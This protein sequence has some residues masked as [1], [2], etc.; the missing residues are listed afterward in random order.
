MLLVD[1]MPPPPSVDMVAGIRARSMWTSCMWKG[2]RSV[3]ASGEP[4]GK[5][6]GRI[7]P[8]STHVT[9]NTDSM[10]ELRVINYTVT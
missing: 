3:W 8:W 7:G 6:R 5:G 9:H 10:V 4:I 1:S 2:F